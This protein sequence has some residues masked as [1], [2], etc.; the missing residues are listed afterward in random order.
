[1][2]PPRY[3]G[4]LPAV[5][6]PV[7]RRARRAGVAGSVGG[8]AECERPPMVCWGRRSVAAWRLLARAGFLTTWCFAWGA[9]VLVGRLTKARG[10]SRSGS[11]GV[12]LPWSVR[13]IRPTVSS[14]RAP[15]VCSSCVVVGSCPSDLCPR[16]DGISSSGST[17]SSAIS[18]IT[19][20]SISSRIRSGIDNA[21]WQHS[22]G[23]ACIGASRQGHRR[24]VGADNTAPLHAFHAVADTVPARS[25][26]PQVPCAAGWPRLPPSPRL[27][28][29]YSRIRRPRT[30]QV[31]SAGDAA[32]L[33]AA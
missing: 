22:C 32:W 11:R 14:G 15:W 1:M 24:R 17:I 16:S 20:S 7:A 10:R 19:S 4:P 13:D 12:C 18:S 21:R 33:T 31:R 2:P 5:L 23:G 29:P 3:V 26:H 25:D 6:L 9:A 28:R 8:V 27:L 30:A